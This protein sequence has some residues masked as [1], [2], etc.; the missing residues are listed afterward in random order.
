MAEAVFQ[1]F[2]ADGSLQIDL[3]TRITKVSGWGVLPN[4]GITI[5]DPSFADGDIWFFIQPVLETELRA[6]RPLPDF[7][8]YNRG[9]GTPRIVVGSY[10]G[11]QS[12]AIWGIY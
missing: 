8:V 10:T 6:P 11:E 3:A 7:T 9:Q 1:L 5:T 4:G 2:R 12:T